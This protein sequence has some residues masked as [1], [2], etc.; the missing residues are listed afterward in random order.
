LVAI[1]L[2]LL[3]PLLAAKQ[4]FPQKVSL[5]MQSIYEKYQLKNVINASGRMTMLDVSTPKAE[6]TERVGYGLN[7]YFE[8]KDLVNKTGQYI[9]KLLKVEN[10][11]VVSCASAGIA[12]SVATVIVK[13]ILIYFITFTLHLNL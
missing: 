4:L 6:V 11:V 12:Q 7:H 3:L 13:T 9:A 8:I 5:N 10:A 1:S 2:C